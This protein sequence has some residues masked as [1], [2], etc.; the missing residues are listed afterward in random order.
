MA[1]LDA[2]IEWGL[3]FE[4]KSSDLPNIDSEVAILIKQSM[5]AW[6]RY[7]EDYSQHDN[8]GCR[9]PYIYGERTSCGVYATAIA[10]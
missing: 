2:N 10:K 4:N 5:D 6:H 8:I 3:A 1:K 7:I 9:F